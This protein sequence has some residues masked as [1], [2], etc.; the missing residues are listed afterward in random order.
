MHHDVFIE[1]LRTCIPTSW[2]R[3]N[4][5]NLYEGHILGSHYTI[6]KSYDTKVAVVNH[7]EGTVYWDK[8]YSKTTS[9]QLTMWAHSHSMILKETDK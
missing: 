9:K 1:I 6:L 4:S 2:T 8:K 7:N 3:F 5:M